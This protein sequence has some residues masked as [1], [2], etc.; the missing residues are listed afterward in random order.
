MPGGE[1]GESSDS[2]EDEDKRSGDSNRKS[3]RLFCVIAAGGN[4]SPTGKT[5]GFRVQQCPLLLEH[6]QQGVVEARQK[7]QGE[8]LGEG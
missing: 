4:E 2:S 7:I 1:K 5:K 6:Q 3:P 8:L